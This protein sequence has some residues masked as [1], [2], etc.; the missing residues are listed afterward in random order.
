MLTSSQSDGP[1]PTGSVTLAP[2]R[3]PSTAWV[4]APFS[5]V[6]LTLVIHRF[7]SPC[8][9]DER[10]GVEI[11]RLREVEVEV[12]ATRVPVAARAPRGGRIA[13][14][15]VERPILRAVVERRAV[16]A[17]DDLDVTARYALV[18]AD[19]GWSGK[20]GNRWSWLTSTRVGAPSPSVIPTTSCD[21]L[22]W[23]AR[24]RFWSVMITP[25]VRC[26]AC[27]SAWSVNAGADSTVSCPS[28]RPAAAAS[29]S[30]APSP[31]TSTSSP[32]AR[33]IGTGSF[34]SKSCA[35]VPYVPAS[36]IPGAASSSVASVPG[37]SV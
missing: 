10:D 26:N 25:F 33:M 32:R 11:V 4:T 28:I 8:G 20:A 19:S 5:V 23:R 17:R 35:A 9:A 16:A 22:S 29:T 15:R 37:G 2:S 7:V 30:P 31:T 3:K 27:A 24:L 14:D 1:R 34:T 6:N 12:L 36:T 13:V 21:V 18:C